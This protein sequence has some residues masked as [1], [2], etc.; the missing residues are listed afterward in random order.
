MSRRYRNK[1]DR[2]LRD[3]T[4]EGDDDGYA[5]TGPHQLRR[6]KIEGK[7]GGVC[8]G[9]ADYLGWDHTMV[10]IITILLIVFTG[11]PLLAYFILWVLMPSDTRAPYVR[12]YR[13]TKSAKAKVSAPAGTAASSTTYS[14][15]R[16]KFLSLETRLQ[17]LEKSIT[18]KEWKLNRDFRDL[19][20]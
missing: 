4:W 11:V 5:Y 12:E 7:L 13:E 15:V 2:M 19:E 18:S 17:D 8:A 1:A 6:N 9:I 20:I 14:D 10:R 16:S 3:E